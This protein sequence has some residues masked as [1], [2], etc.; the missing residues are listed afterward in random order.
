MRF[1]KL[2]EERF[3]MTALVRFLAGLERRT[4]S[5][6]D[7]PLHPLRGEGSICVSGILEEVPW[8]PEPS[9]PPPVPGP[10][11]SSTFRPLICLDLK[12]NTNFSINAGRNKPYSNSKGRLSQRL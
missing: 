10:G 5:G 1:F 6:T 7:V 4:D 3:V 2:D 9:P 11:G 8:S 12:V